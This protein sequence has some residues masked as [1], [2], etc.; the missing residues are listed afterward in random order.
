MS[1]GSGEA[2]V[3][4]VVNKA[5]ELGFGIVVESETQKPDGISEVKRCIDYLKSLGK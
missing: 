5:I 1:L 2:P 3:E 4:A